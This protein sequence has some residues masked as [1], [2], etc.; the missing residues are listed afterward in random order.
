MKKLRQSLLIA[1]LGVSAWL[2]IW[3]D[4]STGEQTAADP[5]PADRRASTPAK[6]TAPA[7]RTAAPV[8][9]GDAETEVV[10]LVIA[11]ITPREVLI[12]TP[13]INA[14]IPAE[15]GQA[16]AP[17]LS[18]SGLFGIQSWASPPP[19]PPPPPEPLTPPPPM[20]P[21]LPFLY[22]G[23]KLDAGQWEVYLA[24]GDMTYVAELQSVIDGIYR[25]DS[26]T[27]STMTLTFLPLNKVQTLPLGDPY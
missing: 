22:L 8:N 6:T 10:S 2:A 14:Q 18:A 11:R 4:R 25:V 13:K 16:P 26:I 17:M 3:G 27:P 19:P 9:A 5:S 21:P 20:A 1:G 12:E 7:D 23:K 24:V 15:G